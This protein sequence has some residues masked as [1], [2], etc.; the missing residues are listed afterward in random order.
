MKKTYVVKKMHKDDYKLFQGGD[1]NVCT[2]DEIVC[3]N[4]PDEAIVIA[5]EN[6]KYVVFVDQVKTLEQILAEE[7]AEKQ[8][9][10]AREQ[11]ERE[12]KAKKAE[13]EAKRAAAAGMTVEEYKK[14][15]AQKT[16]IARIKREIAELE[17]ELTKKQKYLKKLEKAS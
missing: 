15:K 7:E 4:T 9:Q 1:K 12:A 17:E 13:A 16:K 8:E 10:L 3:A 11:K 5:Q 14:A 2:Q 6:G